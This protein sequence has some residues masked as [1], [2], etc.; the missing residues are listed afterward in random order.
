VTNPYESPK[1][2]FRPNEPPL[3]ARTVGTFLAGFAV[4]M[5]LTVGAT[6]IS[7]ACASALATALPKSLAGIVFFMGSPAVIGPL[8]SDILWRVTRHSNRPYAM[9]AITFGVAAF[10]LFGGCFMAITIL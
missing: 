2:P 5:M 4:A 7:L 10:L 8:C 1:S 6:V 9:G 3:T